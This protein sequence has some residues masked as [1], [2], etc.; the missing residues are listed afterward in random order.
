MKSYKYGSSHCLPCLYR[1]HKKLCCISNCKKN[2]KLRAAQK[3]KQRTCSTWPLETRPQ[4]NNVTWRLHH[5]LTWKKLCIP[6]NPRHH[7]RDSPLAECE[8]WAARWEANLRLT[9]CGSAT[10]DEFFSSCPSLIRAPVIWYSLLIIT[11]NATT[12]SRTDCCCSFKLDPLGGRALGSG[13]SSPPTNHSSQIK[14]ERIYRRAGQWI[15]PCKTG[16]G[17]VVE[18]WLFVNLSLHG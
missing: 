3:L 6:H 4:S 14:R 2:V 16:W 15:R 5:L 1:W 8:T 11:A 13:L 7:T 17:F 9:E 10:L 12:T 18:V